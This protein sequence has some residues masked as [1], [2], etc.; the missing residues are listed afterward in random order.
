MKIR[1]LISSDIPWVK[2]IVT[3]YFGSPQI[4]SRGILHDSQK[5]QGFIAE[6]DS[7]RAGLLQFRFDDSQCEIVV[8]LSL[9]RRRGIG[10]ALLNSAK[11]MANQA[12]CTRLWLITTNNNKGALDFYRSIG[13]NQVA[14]YPGAVRESRK[15]KPEIPEFDEEGIPIEDEIEFELVLSGV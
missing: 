10:R 8:L 5:L 15:L 12:E 11:A 9:V 3:K 13:W 2:S 14:V 6:V 4:V 7:K 1:Q